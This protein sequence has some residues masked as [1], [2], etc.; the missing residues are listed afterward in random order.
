[1]ATARKTNLI[2][3]TS[4]ELVAEA[5]R[6]IRQA[7]SL[8]RNKLLKQK[9]SAEASAELDRRLAERGIE[10]G[11]KAVRVPVKDQ[12]LAAL[13]GGGRTPM[14]V[15][16]KRVKGATAAEITAAIDL[17]ARSGEAHVVVRTA[18]EALVGGG[19]HVLAPAEIAD[20][21]R[22][23]K[24]LGDVLKK[25][26]KKPAAKA[27]PRSLLREDL[28]ALLAPI[29][30]LARAAPPGADG[31][32]ARAIVDEAL[33]RLA[34]PAIFLVRIPDLVRSLAGR[35]SMDEV[36]RALAEAAAEGAIE[37]R[38]EQGGE[39]LD[40]EDGRLCPPGPRGSVFSYARRLSP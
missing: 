19:E 10:I 27:P 34:D 25:V 4:P 17:L 3:H 38:P 18:A 23:V 21:A 20:L 24:Q 1:V 5:E 11:P 14:K 6:A 12:I 15:L 40:A 9:L 2:E 7:G 13:R 30:D 35:L 8:A 39:F 32:G 31:A 26:T 36:H 37:L 16:A 28:A 29:A 22:V 33:Q